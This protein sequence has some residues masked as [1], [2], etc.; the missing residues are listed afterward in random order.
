MTQAVEHVAPYPQQRTCPY[1]P[2]DGLRALPDQGPIHD[3]ELYDG[4]PARLVTSYSL[5]KQLLADPRLSVDRTLPGFP[6]MSPRLRAAIA[7]RLVLIGMDPP[8]HDVHRRLVNPEFAL[9]VVRGRRAEIQ[10]IVDRTLDEVV[11]QGPPADLVRMFAVPIPSMVI[12]HILGVPYADHE[13]FQDAARRMILAEG[14]EQTQEAG[15]AL[16]KYFQRLVATPGHGPEDGLLH[17]LMQEQVPTG[18]LTPLEVVQL[19]LV[20]LVAGHETTVEMIALGILTLLEHPD[21]LARLVSDPSQVPGAVEELLRLLSVTDTA[22]LRV[23]VAD[24]EIDGVRIR[25]G[26]GVIISNA[27]GNRDPAVHREPDLLDIDRPTNRQHLAFGYGIH[28]CLGQSLARLELEL[29]LGTLFHRLPTLRLARPADQLPI[30]DASTVQ[31]IRELPVT[32]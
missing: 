17:R 7:Q 29:T 15:Q 25:A 28:Q 32:W 3:V 31:G 12:S 9:K 22:G 10:D 20:I 21:Q 8:V 24:I 6:I 27:L 30:Q 18:A 26:E 2:P 23:A 13:F 14:P 16:F 1:H 4:Q 5:G 11:R 19:G